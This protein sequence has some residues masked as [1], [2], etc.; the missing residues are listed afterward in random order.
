MG[1]VV[2]EGGTLRLAWFPGADPRLAACRGP[3]D[4]D[5]QALADMLARRLGARDAYA[6][7]LSVLSGSI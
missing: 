7:R 4:D 2:K 5:A 6:A 1:S 3:V